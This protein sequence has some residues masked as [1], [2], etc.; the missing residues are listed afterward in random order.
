M[1]Q[2]CHYPSTSVPWS[3]LHLYENTVAKKE[4]TLARVGS[5]DC[6]RET[7]N[8]GAVSALLSVLT[9]LVSVNAR[10]D[11]ACS[12]RYRAV[13]VTPLWSVSPSTAVVVTLVR[14]VVEPV[15]YASVAL[16]R[17]VVALLNGLPILFQWW[18]LATC[19][20]GGLLLTFACFRYGLSVC[21]L[22]VI[23]PQ[24]SSVSDATTARVV[25]TARHDRRQA[26]RVDDV[27]I[28]PAIKDVVEKPYRKRR[29]V[30]SKA[31]TRIFTRSGKK[32]R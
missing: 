15:E 24:A 14:L 8:R 31:R 29:V 12:K 25:S 6:S 28:A 4:A 10:P 17:C 16:N 13:Y 20:I 21:G 32:D 30:C 22:L 9:G 5:R 18:V 27:D 23:E 7:S 19:T 2:N 3:W 11:D 26:R 1:G